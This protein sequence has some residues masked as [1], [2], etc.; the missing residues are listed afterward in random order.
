MPWG[1]KNQEYVIFDHVDTSRDG[2]PYVPYSGEDPDHVAL[3]PCYGV[4]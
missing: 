2:G 4:Y 1:D 3:D